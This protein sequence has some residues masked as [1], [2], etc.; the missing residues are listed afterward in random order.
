MRS[1]CKAV[2]NFGIVYGISV[3]RSRRTSAWPKGAAPSSAR[4][5][6]AIRA[7]SYMETIKETAREQG[8]VTTLFG[9]RR[10]A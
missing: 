5:W 3:S 6:T 7:W 2:I 9:R 1:S 8:Y 4:I 10:A